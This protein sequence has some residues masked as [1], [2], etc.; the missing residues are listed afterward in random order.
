MD[1]NSREP[2]QNIIPFRIKGVE[3]GRFDICGNLGIGTT[4]PSAI[5]DVV[6]N[7]KINGELYVNGNPLTSLTSGVV[8]NMDSQ[9]VA[10]TALN[11]QKKQSIP[12]AAGSLSLIH[13]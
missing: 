2:S 10:A 11:R 9:P 8:V 6:G 7:V 4:A 5:L 1:V 3:V 13:I 12:L